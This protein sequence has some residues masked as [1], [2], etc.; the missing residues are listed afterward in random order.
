[1]D[2]GMKIR[3]AL[4]C[5]MLTMWVIFRARLMFAQSSLGTKLQPDERQA[6]DVASL[7]VKCGVRIVVI[8]AC[9]SAAG[10]NE[11]SNIAS[12][13][14]R[15]GIS[16][17][18]GMSFNVF[19]LSADQ[20][21]RDFYKRYLG[22]QISP[23][24]AVSRARGELRRNSTRM[25]KYHTK[26]D[27]EDHLVPIIHCQESEIEYLQQATPVSLNAESP[28]SGHPV[29]SELI[30]REGDLLRLEWLLTQVE[31]NRIHLQ[32]SP[33]VGKS[34][35]LQEA[36]AWWQQTGLYQRT[37]YIQ[38][39]DAEFR[40]CTTDKIL[41]LMASQS[42]IDPKDHSTKSLIA[43]IDER[44]SLIVLD[45]IDALDWSSNMTLSEHQRQLWLCLKRLKRCSIVVLSRTEDLWLGTAIQSWII[46]GPI[47][48]SNS[49]ALATG[50]LRSLDFPSKLATQDDQSYFEQLITMSQGNPLA[51]RIIAYDLGKYFA[52]DPCATIL[53]HLLSLLQLRPVF[54]DKERLVSDGEARAVV[55]ILEWIADD[56]NTDS[57]FDPAETPC[58]GVLPL[59]D[60]SLPVSN[61][62]LESL[63]HSIQMPRQGPRTLNPMIR[64]PVTDRK[65]A[66]CGF[67]SAAVFLG[68]WHNLP[69]D[70]E[71]FI[72]TF[73]ILLVVRHYLD[74]E[75]FTRFR[76]HLC[77]FS[78]EG[79]RDQRYN[80]KI[81][82]SKEAF[83][84][85]PAIARY[86]VYAAK[87][88]FAKFCDVR[89]KC[90]SHFVQDPSERTF[91]RSGHRLRST[92][93][94][95]HPLLSLVS[96][97]IVVRALYPQS[98]VEDIEIARDAQY[99]HR[100]FE[101]A[102]CSA[103]HPSSPF[104]EAMKFE[105][106]FDFFNYLS[107]IIS[108]QRMDSW[109]VGEH[110]VVQS[111]VLTAALS[112]PR[113][114][115][116]VDRVLSLFIEKALL[117]ITRIRQKFT[118]SETGGYDPESQN[119]DY[120]SWSIASDLEVA[121]VNALCRAF[122]CS[123]ILRKPVEK[124]LAQWNSVRTRPMFQ[125]WKHTDPNIRSLLSRN[126]VLN[127]RFLEMMRG[128]SPLEV[129]TMNEC[130]T[131]FGQLRSHVA[132]SLG[133]KEA[134]AVAE[135]SAEISHRILENTLQSVGGG[136][137]ILKRAHAA[138][139]EIR[140]EEG[141]ANVVDLRRAVENLEALLTEEVELDNNV[142]TRML[143]HAHLASVH[144]ALGNKA[145]AVQHRTIREDLKTMLE[146]E[147]AAQMQDS[148]KISSAFA[149]ESRRAKGDPVNLAQNLAL[150]LEERQAELAK[151]ESD[152]PSD[153]LQVLSCVDRIADLLRDLGRE[154]EA[155]DHYLRVIKGRE[156]LL[157]A[158][159]EAILNVRFARSKL[160]AKL[161][162]YDESIE[163]LRLLQKSYTEIGD[164]RTLSNV[165]GTLGLELQNSVKWE[166][167]ALAKTTQHSRLLEATALL[168]QT[169][170]T[171]E[172]L[173]EPGDVNISTANSNLGSLYQSQGDFAKA[174]SCYESAIHVHLTRT[175]D[176]GDQRLIMSRNNLACLWENMDKH[177]AAANLF[178]SLLEVCIERYEIWHNLSCI[179]MS[180]LYNNYEKKGAKEKGLSFIQK[181]ISR[182]HASLAEASGAAKRGGLD[183]LDA[184]Y[185]FGRTL[186][187]CDAHD[188]AIT[189]LEEVATAWR[190]Q[191]KRSDDF[192]ALLQRL[193]RSYS[194]RNPPQLEAEHQI[195][196]ELVKLR[197]QLDG[198]AST[199]TLDETGHLVV[200]LRRLKCFE[201]AVKIQIQLIEARKATIGKENETT[202]DN[203][204]YLAEIYEQIMDLP[205]AIESRRDVYLARRNMDSD[206]PKT[207]AQTSRIALLY[208]KLEEWDLAID[209][210]KDE[211][212]EWRRIE[213]ADSQNALIALRSLMETFEITQR[214]TEARQSADEMI[215][216]RSRLL[217]PSHADT[218]E[219]QRIKARVCRK[220]GDLNEAEQIL[221]QVLSTRSQ[222]PA[223]DAT[224]C[225]ALASLSAVYM[226]RGRLPRA[227]EL[228]RVAWMEGETIEGG[229]HQVVLA[230]LA[231]AI[232][233]ECDATKQWEDAEDGINKALLVWRARQ[234][235]TPALSKEIEEC[236]KFLAKVKSSKGRA[237]SR[238][239]PART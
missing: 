189:L 140:F 138:V 107:L 145:I 86:C 162:R 146:P 194:A 31:G 106:D 148:Y 126:I 17:A 62:S 2:K 44:S 83:G 99:R 214:H 56:V 88:S 7:L 212:D 18:V 144:A 76:N 142:P 200:C 26:V 124:Y 50:I 181:C 164:A 118:C 218:L 207:I 24:A 97:S 92:C 101:W 64:E 23:I 84:L 57:N 14:I 82:T 197:S 41:N 11:A 179:I 29:G 90:L 37:I 137:L 36:S 224:R 237:T 133:L 32:G 227:I 51:I 167:N 59:K 141:K 119:R 113:R 191:E 216:A 195:C 165:L 232:A 6:A 187:L 226:A 70:L 43:A 182:F 230:H 222:F 21:M 110:W 8:N 93:S 208:E 217:G 236:E 58:D 192:V 60:C 154:A 98:I 177:E 188:Q 169:V 38:L 96:Q 91:G 42:R 178:S 170:K 100:V 66:N 219:A 239:E 80:Y 168:E 9:R 172:D 139:H 134:S 40:D 39:A 150:Q 206:S 174:E 73:G 15:T 128:P 160:L 104:H 68:F 132:Q 77:E 102:R 166:G 10:S 234:A 205:K 108:Y 184:K 30:G 105:L 153:E 163:E 129:K 79:I 190:K 20:F 127:T 48:L 221:D 228:F 202:L 94:S 161:H 78:E 89:T 135:P 231:M 238:I 74:D 147:Q 215:K 95:V 81:L 201:E 130:L 61:N 33:G 211:A 72:V 158:N 16:I 19:S 49:I 12:L 175:S 155:A 123:D 156:R 87:K 65:L 151:A 176:P 185:R 103:Y 131:E 152:E 4:S 235:S 121:T 173:F 223:E 220:A 210:R 63:N 55:E 196:T 54:L 171:V 193:R 53:S 125:V 22:Q 199:T 1:M 204:S 3:D 34:R 46:L 28:V 198:P 120:R 122:F 45:S 47:D 111:F 203:M 75:A 136:D 69:H 180:N 13:L 5:Q 85:S 143:I 115:R 67:Y 229:E 116:L 25:T 109:P 71:P 159:D 35:L 52:D 233:K 213:G 225:L 114:M 117:V 183:V 149:R 186:S 157:L 112:D 209:L 27:L